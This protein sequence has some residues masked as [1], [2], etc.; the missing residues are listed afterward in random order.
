MDITDRSMF[1]NQ[2]CKIFSES[3]RIVGASVLIYLVPRTFRVS[4]QYITDNGALHLYFELHS[5]K[6]QEENEW[7]KRICSS[8]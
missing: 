1:Y 6:C 2:S 7:M 5:K 4:T 3:K 8:Q